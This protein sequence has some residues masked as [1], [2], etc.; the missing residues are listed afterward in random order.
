MIKAFA[1][2][3]RLRQDCRPQIETRRHVLAIELSVRSPKPA[4][5]LLPAKA[6]LALMTVLCARPMIAAR[7]QVLDRVVV[8]I[9]NSVITQSDVEREYRLEM[10]LSQGR[11]PAAPP[12]PAA[13]QQTQ[14]KL[15]NQDLLQQELS[16]YPVNAKEIQ[17]RAAE[18]LSAVRRMFKSDA[19]FQAALCA[20]G[21][22]SRELLDH[23]EEQQRILRMIDER[24]RPAAGV[25]QEEIEDYYRTTFVPEFKKQSRSAPPSVADVQD[26]IQE[27]LVQKKINQLLDEWLSELRK[28]HHV[29]IISQ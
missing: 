19:D 24:L 12:D 11:V 20:V 17:R 25:T 6:L 10:F 3:H 23:L 15:I 7:P 14:S 26:K 8:S 28:D 2:H 5:G 21:M 9:E 29:R 27:I 1:R 22:S 13:F 4:L 18:R 16:A